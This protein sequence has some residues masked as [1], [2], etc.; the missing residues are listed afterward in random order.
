MSNIVNS[1][2][3]RFLQIYDFVY[4]F[5]PGYLST[6]KINNALYLKAHSIIKQFYVDC[7]N[8]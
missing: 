7:D 6:W 5:A 8:R 4:R 2:V 1:S 3:T